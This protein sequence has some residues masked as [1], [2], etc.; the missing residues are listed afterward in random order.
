VKK[1]Y[2]LIDYENVQPEAIEALDR[3]HY[4]AIVFIGSSQTKVT[5]EVASIL[6]RMGDSNHSLRARQ[7]WRAAARA[8]T[9][10]DWNGPGVR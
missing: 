7:R 4:S 1:Y 5:D 6:Q 3:E 10:V 9:S 8:R 2:V